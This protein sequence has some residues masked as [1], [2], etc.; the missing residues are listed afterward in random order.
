MMQRLVGL[1][2]KVS[3]RVTAAVMLLLISLLLFELWMLVLRR[4]YA[5]LRQLRTAHNTLAASL[6]HSPQ[7]L[8][9]LGRVTSELRLLM[10]K[11]NGQL[12]IKASDDEMAASLMAVLDQSA[13]RHGIELSSLQPGERKQVSVFEEVAFKVGAK[14][15]YLDLCQWMLDLEQSL[16]S[17]A[18]ISE[19]EMKTAGEARE[20]VLSFNI[21]LYRPLQL[22]EGHP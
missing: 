4:P 5:E 10:D 2:G 20:V 11:L 17:N 9:E 22:S 6:R 15:G 7:Q 3:P 13:A 16:G 8:E 12:H 19:F 1:L 21:A 18:A 14:G